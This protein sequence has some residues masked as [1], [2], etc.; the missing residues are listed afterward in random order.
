MKQIIPCKPDFIHVGEQYRVGQLLGSGGSGVPKHDS[1]LT[2]CTFLISIGY[3][4]LGKDIKTEADVALKIG[5]TNCSPSR[6]THEYNMYEAVAGST[7]I[8][9]VLWYGKEGQSEVIILYHLGTSLGDL[10]RKQQFDHER[11]FLYA[12]QMVCPLHF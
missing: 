11:T 7:G 1:R 2:Y 12:S 9:S 4:Y 8:S 10:I 3:V 6:L 5:H